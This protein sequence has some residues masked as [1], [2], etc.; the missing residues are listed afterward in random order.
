MRVFLAIELPQEVRDE[1]AGLQKQLSTAPA[2]LGFAHEFHVTLKFLGEITPVKVD[3][4]KSCLGNV[5]FKPFKA[6]LGKPGFFASGKNVRV[7]WVGIEPADEFIQ[8]QEMV[9]DALEKDFPREKNFK[10]HL[11]L[12]RVKSVSDRNRFLQQL[13][14]LK[15]GD[16]PFEVSEF[17]LKKSTIGSS[18][19]VYDDLA[20]YGS[21]KG[22]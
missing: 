20:L 5:K 2:K 15:I 21:Q 12:A 10:P 11:T 19:A 3:A 17:K 22:F 8:L 7:V 9:N 1:L 6:R 16:F 18:G 14:Q 4:V 13:W